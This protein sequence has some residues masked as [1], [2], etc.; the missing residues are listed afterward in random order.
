MVRALAFHQWNRCHTCK[1]SEFVGSLLWMF[2]A[3]YMN[4]VL[5]YFGHS[6]LEGEQCKRGACERCSILKTFVVF[7]PAHL[8]G[9]IRLI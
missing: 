9:L 8:V 7:N 6:Y 2:H 4:N 5:L 3:S 1:W